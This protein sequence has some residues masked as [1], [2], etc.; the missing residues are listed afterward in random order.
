MRSYVFFIDCVSVPQSKVGTLNAMIDDAK[1]ITYATFIRH[2]DVNHLHEIL[3][4]YERNKRQG[5]TIKDDWSVSFHRSHW[6]GTP[7]YYV[8][9]SSIEYVFRNCEAKGRRGYIQKITQRHK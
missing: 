4:G 2:V 3:P 6:N 8:Q 5:L 7:V 9:H 1:N